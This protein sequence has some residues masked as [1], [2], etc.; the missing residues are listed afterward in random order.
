MVLEDVAYCTRVS[1]SALSEGP[2]R[3]S[4]CLT[5]PNKIAFRARALQRT[6]VSDLAERCHHGQAPPARRAL[7]T[8]PAVVADATQAQASRPPWPSPARGSQ[9]VDRYPR[10]A[11][12]RDRLGGPAPGDGLWLWHDLLASAPRLDQGRC[13]VETPRIASGRV[14]RRGQ[15]RL[16]TCSDRQQLRAGAG[17]GWQDGPQPS[18]PP[19][20]GERAPSDHR[21]G[22]DTLGG[23]DDRRERPRCQPND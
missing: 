6:E 15:D 20:E 17:R 23:G 21:R 14:A 22:R 5:S 7:G 3:R 1:L 19:K 12:D 8:N 11:Q 10:C 4:Y 16:A 13:L 2:V 18:R 9:G